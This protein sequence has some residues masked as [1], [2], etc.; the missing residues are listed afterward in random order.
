MIL[1]STPSCILSKVNAFHDEQL[2][3]EL[4]TLKDFGVYNLPG[5]ITEI[6]FPGN[7][8][9]RALTHRGWEYN[10][11]VDIAHWNIRKRIMLET[12][13]HIFDF[14]FLSGRY[15]DVD[16]YDKRCDSF[17]AVVYYIHILQDHLESKALKNLIMPIAQEHDNKAVIDE[18]L[19]HFEILFEDQK[20]TRVYQTMVS[21]MMLIQYQAKRLVGSGGLITEEKLEDYYNCC[22]SLKDILK[23]GLHILLRRCDWFEKAFPYV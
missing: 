18:L 2:Y 19:K 15:F 6:D 14:G 11:E 8:Y 20:I 3:K 16:R 10:Y 17:A 5:S 21:D 7:A 12:V 23:D 1:S 9:H 4:Q 22:V 13:N